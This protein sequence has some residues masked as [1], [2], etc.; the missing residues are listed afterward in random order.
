M[1]VFLNLSRI[2]HHRELAL[3]LVKAMKLMF[4]QG[5][6]NPRGGN[7]S[8]KINDR[9][10]L[11]TPS[12]VSKY[13]LKTS[14]LIRYDLVSR[15]FDKNIFGYKP[16]IEWRV[17]IAIY[18]AETRAVSVLHA[19]PLHVNL[20]VEIGEF[21]WWKIPIA[22]YELGDA[23]VCIAKPYEPGSI[24]LSNEIGKL[25]ENGCSVIIIPQHG[26]FTWGNDVWSAFDKISA[27]EYLAKY[28]FLQK[29]YIK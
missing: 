23:V 1:E 18:E 6:I 3:D 10:V 21:N 11:L 17:H 5:L 19:H 2:V 12:G 25:V 28:R 24:E 4:I 9:T 26:V 22:K 7:G 20:L 29:I 27:L 8:V 15:E 14:D 13:R 16:S